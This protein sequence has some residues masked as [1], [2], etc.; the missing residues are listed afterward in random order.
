MYN[1]DEFRE[2]WESD[3]K[4]VVITC[5]GMP[6]FSCYTMGDVLMWE[7]VV[8]NMAEEKQREDVQLLLFDL[9]TVEFAY[10]DPRNSSAHSGGQGASGDIAVPTAAGGQHRCLGL[11]E[12]SHWQINCTSFLK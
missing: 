5:E 11:L 6:A 3:F 7:C 8:V 9:Q 1:A 12:L 4:V 10:M 2:E